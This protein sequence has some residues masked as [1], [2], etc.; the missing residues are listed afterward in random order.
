MAVSTPTIPI[1]P[2]GT[3][4][5]V[6]ATIPSGQSLSGKVD[7]GQPTLLGLLLPAAWDAA[8]VSFA[9]SPDDVTYG[10]LFTVAGEYASAAAQAAGDFL[11]VDPSAFY[12]ARFLK[13]RSGTSGTPVTQTADRT[14]TLIVRSV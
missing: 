2:G 3:A 13:V 12:G 11:A 6:T 5:Y 7:L 1:G 14:L 9:V 8:K 4:G 10:P